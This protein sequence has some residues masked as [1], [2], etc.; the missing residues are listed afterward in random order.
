MV[1]TDYD[2]DGGRGPRPPHH[3]TPRPHTKALPP[4]SWNPGHHVLSL[5]LPTTLWLLWELTK[6]EVFCPIG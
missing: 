6:D 2:V 5:I 1:S 3:N 4:G